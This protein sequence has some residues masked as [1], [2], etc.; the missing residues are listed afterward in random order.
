MFR[1]KKKTFRNMGESSEGFMKE[2]PPR[3]HPVPG[4]IDLHTKFETAHVKVL[5]V[6]AKINQ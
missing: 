3:S 2:N 4:F 1:N 5:N 6:T